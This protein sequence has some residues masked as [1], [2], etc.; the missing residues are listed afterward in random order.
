MIGDDDLI[1]PNTLLELD[2]I[3]KINNNIDYFFINS[4]SLHKSHLKALNRPLDIKLIDKNL[5]L[6]M[7]KLKANKTLP[8]WKL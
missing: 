2:K 8:F 3:L 1:L 7:S 5:L 6:P 4:Y